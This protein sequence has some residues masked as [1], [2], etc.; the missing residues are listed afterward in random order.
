MPLLA[1]KKFA[2]FSQEI[3]LASL[4]TSEQDLEKLASVRANTG[5]SY[6]FLLSNFG[7]KHVCRRI[8]NEFSVNECLTELLQS[9]SCQIVKSNIFD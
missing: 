9:C 2:Q 5:K 8:S 6:I 3:G 1:D 4:G 7:N